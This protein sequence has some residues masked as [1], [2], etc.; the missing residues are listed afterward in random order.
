MSFDAQLFDGVLFGSLAQ[1]AIFDDAIF[2][3]GPFD[4]GGDAPPIP[5]TPSIPV[6]QPFFGGGPFPR[7]RYREEELR[8]A[9]PQAQ[10]EVID[11]AVEKAAEAIRNAPD[12]EPIV[13]DAKRIYERVFTG[14]R[15]ELRQA[16]L[17][18]LQ[19]EELE[20]RRIEEMWRAEVQKRVRQQEEDEM[21]IFL[22][23]L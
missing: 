2:D 19:V 15:G 22:I 14:L 16:V 20:R 18:T 11:R 23:S 13:L 21:M 5:P 1:T 10:L 3:S 8:E 4:T 17:E 7:R 9:L 6:A 12:P